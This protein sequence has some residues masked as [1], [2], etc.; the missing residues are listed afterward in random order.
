[1]ISILIQ[2]SKLE[3][4]YLKIRHLLYS[5]SIIVFVVEFNKWKVFSQNVDA[6]IVCCTQ[7]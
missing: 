3:N 5:Y 2:S 6:C 1:M 4:L 7:R